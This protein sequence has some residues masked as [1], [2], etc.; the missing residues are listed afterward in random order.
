MHC[1]KR[2]DQTGDPPVGF[3]PKLLLRAA[4][5]CWLLLLP[6]TLHLAERPTLLDFFAG[7]NQAGPVAHAKLA[8][9]NLHILPQLHS[10]H[11]THHFKQAMRS[12]RLNASSRGLRSPAN[13]C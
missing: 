12:A 2:L 5:A 11:Q 3:F 9:P 1:H 7:S 13:C 10:H 4:E 8:V 6:V